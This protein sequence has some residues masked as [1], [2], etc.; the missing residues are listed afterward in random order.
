LNGWK[1]AIPAAFLLASL[2]GCIPTQ[3]ELRMEQDLEEMKRRLAQSERSVVTLREDR[4]DKASE[5][6]E[7]LA[8]QQAEVQAALD[9]LRVEFQSVNGRLED[10]AQ[11]SARM[12]EDISLVQ[13]DLSLKVSALEDRLGEVEEALA[14]RPVPA[15]PEVPAETPETVYQRGLELIQKEGAFGRGREQMELFLKRYPE[16]ELAVNA[17]Y[18]IGEAFFGEKKFEDAILQF[19]DVVQKHGN[20]PKAAAALL[21]QGLAFRALGDEK[22]ARVILQQVVERFPNSEEAKKAKERLGE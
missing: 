1:K 21:K 5:R 11:T 19:Q 2:A 20:H 7:L 22:N 15:T 17:M 12:R 8:K 10:M 4:S 18:W 14:A 3:R 9:T 16:H 6:L 13:D